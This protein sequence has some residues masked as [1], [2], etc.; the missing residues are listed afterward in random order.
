MHRALIKQFG[1]LTFEET[2]GEQEINAQIIRV[3]HQT[4]VRRKRRLSERL[5]IH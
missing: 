2:T 4:E 3:Y 1:F 5:K